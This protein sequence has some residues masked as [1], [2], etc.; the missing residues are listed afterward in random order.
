MKVTYQ[1]ESADL[2][3]ALEA[4]MASRG[5]PVTD[6]DEFTVGADGSVTIVVTKAVVDPRS[7][8]GNTPSPITP[9]YATPPIGVVAP[10]VVAALAAIPG[11]MVVANPPL[12]M[13]T[14][15]CTMFAL[16]WDGS[17]DAGDNGEG[18]FTDPSTGKPYATANK[19]LAGASLPREVLLSTFGISD[20]WKTPTVPTDANTSAIWSKQADLV[21]Q[22]ALSHKVTLNIDSGGLSARDVTLVDAG[23]E[24]IG[25]K[26]CC[27]GHGLDLTYFTAHELNTGGDA[28]ATL[29][30]LVDGAPVPIKGWDFAT[31][32]VG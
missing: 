16:N 27:I 31:G 1:L 26:G 28:A 22:F 19:T 2:K 14:Q 30:V 20:D 9:P 13:T 3:A 17:K 32:R 12:S 24:A 21:R 6:A 29:E 25:E 8:G 23:P 5:T 18:F 15:H 10:S 7:I 4:W 11:H